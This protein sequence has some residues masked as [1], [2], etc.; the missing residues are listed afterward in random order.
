MD[1]E[2]RFAGLEIVTWEDG[3][4]L[5]EPARHAYRI[6][7]EYDSEVAWVDRFAEFLECSGIEEVRAFVVGPWGDVSTGDPPDPAIEALV[8][9][10]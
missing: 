9:A 8:G 6:G 7:V 3:Q 2:S 1:N 5:E 10:R 4:V